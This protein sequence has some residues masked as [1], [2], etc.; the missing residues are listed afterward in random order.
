MFARRSF[1]AFLLASATITGS[2]AETHEPT[3]T[4]LCYHIVESP[5]DTK[6]TLSRE[7]YRQ[8]MEYLASA[9]YNVI[10]FAHLSEFIHGKRK[11][12]PPNAVV[13]TIDDGWKCTHTHIYPEMK[14]LRM[15]FTVFIYP[16]FIGQSGYA[17]S[18]DQVREMSDAGVDIQS[19]SY[20]HPFLTQRRHRTLNDDTYSDWLGRE[21]EESKKLIEKRT[22]KPVR[23]LAYPYGDY[24]SRVVTAAQKSG[25]EAAVTAEF[26][27]VSRKS[28]PFRLRRVVIESNMSFA[29]FRRYMGNSP[30]SLENIT[31][32]TGSLFVPD[33]PVIAAKIPNF[34]SLDPN[35]VGIS[36][37]GLGSVPYSYNPA[38]GTISTVVREPLKG[39]KQQVIVWGRDATSG[40]RVEGTW[41]FYAQEL[42]PKRPATVAKKHDKPMTPAAS[43]GQVPG[44]ITNRAVTPGAAAQPRR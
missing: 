15:P 32:A 10:P 5:S 14:R 6:F 39:N 12:L 38:D 41:T 36:V 2:A 33:Q 31:P 28:D 37:V 3:A 16:K 44:N 7:T 34:K 21:L 20:S 8:Q 42:P 30:V 9:G 22:G 23:F 25:Y 11:T 24:D 43:G 27:A 1:L 17:L 18:W 4:I 26:G 35:S 29:D 40:K 19:H 13:V